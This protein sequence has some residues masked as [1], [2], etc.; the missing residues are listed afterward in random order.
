VKKQRIVKPADL[1]KTTYLETTADVDAFL[2]ALRKALEAAI[3]QNERIE[4]R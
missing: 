1:A 2:L 4:I 3:A